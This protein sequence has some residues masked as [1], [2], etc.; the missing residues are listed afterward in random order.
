[1]GM[2]AYADIYFGFPLNS[3]PW[4]AYDSDED[5]DDEYDED[6]EVENRLYRKLGLAEP[7]V[8]YEDD[9]E[10]HRAHWKVQRAAEE[11][12]T[13]E[14][15]S[16]HS[17]YGDPMYHVHVKRANVHTSWDSDQR[18]EPMNFGD[19]AAMT[20]DLRAFCELMDIPFE[21]PGWYL[22]ARYS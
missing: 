22:T 12:Q 19:E 16:D 3:L 17:D 1:M 9:P 15:A 13:C 21:E 5:G 2:D 14:V 8:A 20:E 11:A 10:A 7:T 18:F 4:Q 6:E